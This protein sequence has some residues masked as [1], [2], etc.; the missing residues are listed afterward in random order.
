MDRNDKIEQLQYKAKEMRDKQN[1]IKRLKERLEQLEYRYNTLSADEI[2][3]LM[4]EIGMRSFSL[5]DGTHFLIKPILIINA[6]KEKMD[7]I[8]DWLTEHGHGGMVKTNI[9]VSLPK[10]SE[11]LKDITETLDEMGIDYA[12]TK[13]IHH[14]T[15]GKWGREMDEEGMVIPEDLFSVYRTNKT[16]I[17]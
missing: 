11:R 16:I 1:E 8:D 3:S 12:V 6:P 15:L 2:P 9:D 10:A 5:D 14:M 17:D 4:S 13:R 7:A